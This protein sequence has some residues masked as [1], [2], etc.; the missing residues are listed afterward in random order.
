MRPGSSA[1][2]T[3]SGPSGSI[4]P[5]PPDTDH[6]GYRSIGS[7]PSR[8]ARTANRTTSPARALAA[9]GNSSYV[10]P[11]SSTTSTA[12]LVDT[13]PATTSTSVLPAARPCTRPTASTVATRVSALRYR[14]WTCG[15]TPPVRE[16]TAARI[17]ADVPTISRP[18]ARV[19]AIASG[20][21]RY[22]VT[23]AT[24]AA[25]PERAVTV[26]SPGCLPVTRPDTRST[27]ATSGSLDRK[28]TIRSLRRVPAAS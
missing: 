4:R 28:W 13:S 6:W 17:G 15:S 20:T 14:T 9:E 27:S 22:T 8:E 2:N 18:P 25:P 5:P 19:A 12:T 11:W 10:N 23:V 7:P 26:A 16:L 3:P 1:T 24:A 21:G